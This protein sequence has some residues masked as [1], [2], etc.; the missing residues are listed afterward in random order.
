MLYLEV[1]RLLKKIRAILES[2]NI[3]I[4]EDL[5]K[6]MNAFDNALSSGKTVAKEDLGVI[7]RYLFPEAGMG[8]GA[9]LGYQLR[10]KSAKELDVLTTELLK[11]I[12]ET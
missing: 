8:Y 9:E 11:T 12:Q 10:K 4:L 1:A 2:N 7:S 6:S 3:S 5:A